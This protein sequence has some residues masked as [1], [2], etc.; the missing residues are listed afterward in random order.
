[1]LETGTVGG[2]SLMARISLDGKADTNWWVWWFC[3]CFIWNRLFAFRNAIH[4]QDEG[5]KTGAGHM[6][7]RARNISGWP[8]FW[9]GYFG[10]AQ[11][12]GRPFR[13]GDFGLEKRG[14]DEFWHSRSN[15]GLE[16]LGWPRFR[17]GHFGLAQI[18][19]SPFW[20]GPEIP[21]R[22]SN[23]DITNAINAAVVY[24]L[25]GLSLTP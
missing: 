21:A 15:V 4:S 24:R 25:D 16:I 14:A 18:L 12:L 8:G 2:V 10:L 6:T 22:S 20:A 17:A 3:G 5:T 11:I 7:G 13:A 1:M 19:G 23:S 9:A